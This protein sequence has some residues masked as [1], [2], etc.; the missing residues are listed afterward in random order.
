MREY[1][2]N[3]SSVFQTNPLLPCSTISGTPPLS[4]ASTGFFMAMVGVIVVE[5]M[6]AWA[7]EHGGHVSL[8]RGDNSAG[9]FQLLDQ[10]MLAI[11]KALKANF[12]PAGILNRHR[13]YREF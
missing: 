2:F 11:H 9:A 10:A 8:Y 5:A 3:S 1:A 4:S 13:M 7:R 12:D 6:R